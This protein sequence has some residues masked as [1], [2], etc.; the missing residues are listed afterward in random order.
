[1]LAEIVIASVDS[2]ER[3]ARSL[4]EAIAGETGRLS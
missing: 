3:L 4:V 1:V 2:D